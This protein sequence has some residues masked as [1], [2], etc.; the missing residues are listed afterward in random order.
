MRVKDPAM[1][2]RKRLNRKFTQRDLAFLVKRSHAA[3]GA[4]ETGKMK[5]CTEDLALLIAARLDVD[6]EDLFVLEEH[7]VMPSLASPKV[8]TR[9]HEKVA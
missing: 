6:W 5:T 8:S 1:L 4:L 3:I 9:H 2:R 7:E